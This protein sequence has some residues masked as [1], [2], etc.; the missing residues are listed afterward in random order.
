MPCS[1]P[2]R[3]TTASGGGAYSP[4]W[5]STTYTLLQLRDLGVD[6]AAAPTSKGRPAGP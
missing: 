3:M 2:S 5:T 1:C 4:K 6:P